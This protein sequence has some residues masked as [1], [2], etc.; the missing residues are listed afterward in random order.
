M[1]KRCIL[2]CPAHRA[3]GTANVDYGWKRAPGI[4]QNWLDRDGNEVEHASHPSSLRGLPRGTRVYLGF[5]ASGNPYYR[6][7]LEIARARGLEIR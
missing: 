2:F 5:G 3:H 7:V 6:E 4:G 1:R